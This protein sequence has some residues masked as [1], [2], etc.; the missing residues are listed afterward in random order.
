MIKITEKDF[1]KYI[2]ILKKF[3][4]EVIKFN[5]TMCEMPYGNF[6]FTPNYELVDNFIDL[7]CE[8]TNSTVDEEYESYIEHY[9]FCDEKYMI[10]DLD[11]FY[12]KVKTPKQLYRYLALLDS[13]K[14]TQS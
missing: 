1:C 5:E 14:E 7:L 9:L 2:K 4:N 3:I 8:L 11:T 13:L 12:I 10:I 6:C